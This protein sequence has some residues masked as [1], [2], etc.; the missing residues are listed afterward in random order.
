MTKDWQDFLALVFIMG[1]YVYTII[2]CIQLLK[3]KET[4]HDKRMVAV[5]VLL[6]WVFIIPTMLAYLGGTS[7]I[8]ELA[9]TLIRP[10]AN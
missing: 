9:H 7:T 6:L 3:R 5:G 4:P 10:F 8:V 2:F 1:G